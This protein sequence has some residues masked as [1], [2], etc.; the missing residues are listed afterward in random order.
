MN[1]VRKLTS[2]KRDRCPRLTLQVEHLVR[3]GWQLT[4]RAN[5]HLALESPDHKERVIFALSPS[6]WRG[7]LNT[8]SRLRRAERAWRGRQLR[9][10]TATAAAACPTR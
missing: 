7:D 2:G 4:A 1:A 8:L 9:P 10:A 5:N 6:D 3:L